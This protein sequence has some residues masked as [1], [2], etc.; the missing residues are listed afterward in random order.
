MINNIFKE[1]KFTM[2]SDANGQ[3]AFLNVLVEGTACV[4]LETGVYHKQTRANQILNCHSNHS[5]NHKWSY[6]RNAFKSAAQEDEE[7]KKERISSTCL[8][9]MNKQ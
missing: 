9:E 1:I 2:G 6:I 3:L 7:D 8:T 5:N 4:L